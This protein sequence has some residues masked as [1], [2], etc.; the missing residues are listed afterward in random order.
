[1][2]PEGESLGVMSNIDALNA[3]HEAGLDLVEVAPQA[4]PPVCKIMDFGKFKYQMKK[5][6]QEARKKQVQIVV[7]EVKF[8]PKTD[9][10]DIDYKVKNIL[11]FLSEGNKAK[12]TVVFRGREM[13]HREKGYEL[14]ER[15]LEKIGDAAVIE[16]NPRMEGRIL[17]MV[18][19]PP[20]KGK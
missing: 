6:Q 3:A 14:I 9:V 8:R 12:V 5:K 16:S 1:V 7:K 10:H 19:S 2:G 4:D 18:L 17:F 20:R 11:R 15:I 13:A